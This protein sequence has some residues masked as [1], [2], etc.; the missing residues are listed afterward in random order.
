MKAWEK[1]YGAKV[2]SGLLRM[3]YN[4]KAE[5]TKVGQ[6]ANALEKSDLFCMSHKT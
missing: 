5:V 6:A 3:A 4:D 2:Q 1:L